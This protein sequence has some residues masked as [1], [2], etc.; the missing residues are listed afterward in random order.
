MLP[1]ADLFVEVFVPIDDAI[2][3]RAVQIPRRPG[4]TPACS[5][6]EV[7]TVALVRHLLGRPSQAGFL[8]EVARDWAHVFPHLPTPSE[9][10]RKVRWP[11]GAFELLRQHLAARLPADPWQQVDTSAPSAQASQ[12]GPR[13][14][15]LARPGRVA[16]RPVLDR[17]GT[18]P[19][20]TQLSGARSQGCGAGESGMLCRARGGRVRVLG[21]AHLRRPPALVARLPGRSGSRSATLGSLA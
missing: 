21:E 18:N 2:C 5:D 7:L 17:C 10:N 6:A 14:R 20:R 16:R 8:A 1:L 9:L 15:R 19:A 3:S 4:A 13:S 11:W 12:P